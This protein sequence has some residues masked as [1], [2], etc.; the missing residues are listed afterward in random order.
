MST[1]SDISAITL[2]LLADEGCWNGLPGSEFISGLA[3]ATRRVT[4]SQ[5]QRLF[6]DI[7]WT[8]S[9]IVTRW[10]VAGEWNVED[11]N[12]PVLQIWKGATSSSYLVDSSLSPT[13]R[14]VVEIA[15]GVFEITPD[16]PMPFRNGYCLGLFHPPSAKLNIQYSPGSAVDTTYYEDTGI[17]TIPPTLFSTFGSQQSTDQPLVYVETGEVFI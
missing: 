11:W 3:N 13:K 17:F 8:C 10:V 7:R 14:E 9:G 16:H 1:H 2:L 15:D 5:Q 4:F 12:M 6:P